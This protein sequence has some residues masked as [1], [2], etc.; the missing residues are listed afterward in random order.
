M[1][2]SGTQKLEPCRTW[3]LWVEPNIWPIY[4][5]NNGQVAGLANTAEGYSHA[6][7]W[8]PQTRTMTDLGTLGG[9]V[10]LIR[11]CLLGLTSKAK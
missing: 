8:D 5:N 10:N 6:F 1:P 3:A 2:S 7:L 11:A 9:N 4:I